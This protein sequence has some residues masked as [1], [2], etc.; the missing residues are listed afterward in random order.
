MVKALQNKPYIVYISYTAQM[1]GYH[2]KIP[3]YIIVHIH[4]HYLLLI[5]LYSFK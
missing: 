1:N 5:F 4:T 3:E 2:M